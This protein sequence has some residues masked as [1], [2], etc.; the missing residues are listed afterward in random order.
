MAI[1]QHTKLPYPM[2]FGDVD[3]QTYDYLIGGKLVLGKA[4]LEESFAQLM[5]SDADARLELKKKLISDMAQYILE[6]NLV[7]F[8]QMDDPL[9]FNKTVMVRAYLAPNDQIK[10]LRLANKIV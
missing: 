4:V 1:Q 3:F 7:E 2:P 5:L 8:T 9:T 10:I 6:H